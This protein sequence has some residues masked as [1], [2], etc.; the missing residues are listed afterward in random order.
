[1]V[2]SHIGSMFQAAR[3][4]ASFEFEDKHPE[5]WAEIEDGINVITGT[6]ETAEENTDYKYNFRQ[7]QEFKVK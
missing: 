6:L 4:Q 5:L 7:G 1:M 3:K 2:N